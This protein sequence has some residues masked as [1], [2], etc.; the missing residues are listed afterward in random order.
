MSLVRWHWDVFAGVGEAT[1]ARE[2]GK[3]RILRHGRCFTQRGVLAWI[4]ARARKLSCVRLHSDFTRS[5]VAL[6][7]GAPCR[8]FCKRILVTIFVHMIS[9]ATTAAATSG[10]TN[11]QIQLLILVSFFTS[12]TSVRA[13]SRLA[14]GDRCDRPCNLGWQSARL[15]RVSAE[16][17]QTWRLCA[18]A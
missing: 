15:G 6:R 9:F 14:R 16:E 2:I 11:L 13:G 10:R 17:R 12:P 4:K 3:Y 8:R 1:Q 7:A 18:H 5:G